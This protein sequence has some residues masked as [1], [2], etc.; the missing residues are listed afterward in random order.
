MTPIGGQ[1]WIAIIGNGSIE[2]WLVIEKNVDS[3]VCRESDSELIVL[4]RSDWSAHWLASELRLDSPRY[5]PSETWGQNL[6]QSQFRDATNPSEHRFQPTAQPKRTC[7]Q[8]R[9]SEVGRFKCSNCPTKPQQPK[10]AVEVEFIISRAFFGRIF[11]R[12]SF[13]HDT[14]SLRNTTPLLS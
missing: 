11:P 1:D 8:Q 2:G 6:I 7:L 14:D 3:T 13:L 5:A 4:A 9:L 10:W 12:G